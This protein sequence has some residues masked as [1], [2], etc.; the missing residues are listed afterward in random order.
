MTQRLAPWLKAVVALVI[1]V[2]IGLGVPALLIETIG[3]PLPGTDWSWSDPV[4]NDALLGLLAVVV[5]LFWA[6]TMLCLCVEALA[7]VRIAAGRSAQWMA[8][9]PGTFASQQSLARLLIQAVVAVGV[10]ATVASTTVPPA[11][12]AATA[13]TTAIEP[14]AP[15]QQGPDSA[16]VGVQPVARRSHQ[17]PSVSRLVEVRKGD[18]LWAIA[19]RNLGAGERWREIADLNQHR[20]M[21]DGRRFDP[22]GDLQPGWPLRIPGRAATGRA[23]AS[24]GSGWTVVEA[25]DTLSGIAE[26]AYGDGEEWPR[27]YDANRGRISDPDLIYPGQHLRIPVEPTSFPT[28]PDG[29]AYAHRGPT[30]TPNAPVRPRYDEAPDR[31]TRVDDNSAPSAPVPAALPNQRVPQ[32]SGAPSA[33]RSNRPTE[34]GQQSSRDAAAR[35]APR[36]SDDSGLV[37]ALAG[38]GMLLA[39]GVLAA[40]MAERRRRFR[41]RRSGSAIAPTRHDLVP[42]ESVV[43]SIG[44]AGAAAAH[45]LDLALR[46]LASDI[47]RTGGQLPELR[48]VRLADDRIDLILDQPATAP[49]PAPW[50]SVDGNRRW[51]LDRSV[52]LQETDATA[53]YPAL[54]AV[55]IDAFGA[56]WLLDLECAGVLHLGGDAERCENLARFIA[57]ELALN[58]WSDDVDIAISGFAPELPALNPSRLHPEQGPD[59]ESLGKAVRRMREALTMTGASVLQARLD[60]RG[61]EAWTPQ[62][63]IT[64]VTPD[65]AAI[66]GLLDE[67][68]LSPSR[69]AAA[70]VLAGGAEL[71]AGAR[72]IELDAHG[73]LLLDGTD[74]SA[75]QLTAEQG[76]TLAA[77]LT[78]P[79]RTPD[80]TPGTDAD[81]GTDTAMPADSSST[82]TVGISDAAGALLPEHTSPRNA[83]TPEHSLLMA[84]TQRYVQAAATTADDVEVLAPQVDD[85]TAERISRLDPTLDEDLDLW[86]SE[87]T[88][89]PRLRV[90]GPL[91]V[92]ASGE[93]TVDLARR[94]AYYIELVAYLAL[95][96]DGATT[97]QV[98]EA[99]GVQNNTMH[100]RMNTLRRWLGTDPDTGAPYLPEATL[101]SHAKARGV[102][103][104]RIDKMLCDAGLFKR[105]RTRGQARG[106]EGIDDLRAALELVGGVPFDQQRPGGYGW[107][108]QTPVDQYLT[109]GIVDVAHIVATHGLESRDIELAAWA[110]QIAIAAAPYEDKPRLDLAATLRAGGHSVEAEIYLSREVLNRSDDDAPPPPPSPRTATVLG[111]GR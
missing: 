44:A 45:D 77:L 27:L 75:N 3:N 93:R 72:T 79:A 34:G 1:I 2:A 49:P 25:G 71:I 89:R 67:L 82:A 51:S 12:G 57:A 66:A 55:G 65:Q 95:H 106:A 36:P 62:I 17:T 88:H 60:G 16:D 99:F 54:V 87:S 98:A 28:P 7:E 70:L 84:P 18:S 32:R 68:C 20:V 8:T 94:P 22:A 13:A 23:A 24:S 90:L 101:S 80:A 111:M 46:N 73:H 58:K 100:S 11:H 69:S 19:E 105:L 104:Y 48:A 6:Q 86:H 37:A 59:L 10:T 92:Q 91:E 96:D 108:A 39:G 33:H 47:A 21:P 83:D 56:T 14:T 26:S 43:R 31:R 97:E 74:L 81:P 76:R 29:R 4:T 61:A 103:L 53:P 41:G 102:P 107:L 110:S 35:Q 85:A 64:A 50:S 30:T 78:D 40:F 42:A 52:R 5:W 63:R 109:A 9:V 15:G 38:G